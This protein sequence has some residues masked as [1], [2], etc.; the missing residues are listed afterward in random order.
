[1]CGNFNELTSKYGKVY[2]ELQQCKSFHSHLL[3]EIIQL[4]R[5]A[6]TNSQYSSIEK[7]TDHGRIHKIFHVTEVDNR[8]EIGNLEE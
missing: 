6:V 5:N 8:F 7:L 3:T 2:S 1:M 4:E